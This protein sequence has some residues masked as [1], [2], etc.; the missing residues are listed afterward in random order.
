M[1]VKSWFDLETIEPMSETSPTHTDSSSVSWEERPTSPAAL[2]CLSLHSC[3]FS[4]KGICLHSSHLHAM[5][6]LHTSES[7]FYLF[8]K[9]YWHTY[10]DLF[11]KYFD[12]FPW[13]KNWT[14]GSENCIPRGHFFFGSHQNGFCWKILWHIALG[15]HW[16]KLWTSCMNFTLAAKDRR[17]GST[18]CFF[19][20]NLTE[21][22]PFGCSASPE[23]LNFYLVDSCGNSNVATHVFFFALVAWKSA[24]IWPTSRDRFVNFPH[25]FILSCYR[26]LIS[27]LKSFLNEVSLWHPGT[28]ILV[29]NP[30]RLLLWI[31]SFF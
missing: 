6:L 23:T 25:V 12:V 22:H 30:F 1:T 21:N 17:R 27:C 20:V 28:F 5:T 3:L 8:W 18:Q 16:G 29:D 9:V 14:F 2:P 11:L 10:S 4:L 31:S 7:L 26:Y 19:D 24:N 15:L 13:I